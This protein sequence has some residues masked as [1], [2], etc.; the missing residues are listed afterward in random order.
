M[1]TSSQ[2]KIPAPNIHNKICFITSKRPLP[3]VCNYLHRTQ[4]FVCWQYLPCCQQELSQCWDWLVAVVPLPTSSHVQM[5]PGTSNSYMN[6]CLFNNNIVT[7]LLSTTYYG[8]DNTIQ[9]HDWRVATA[10]SFAAA[11]F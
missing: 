8:K 5:Y 4:P 3:T 9:C 10:V 11:V 1:F 7:V 2:K 6:G